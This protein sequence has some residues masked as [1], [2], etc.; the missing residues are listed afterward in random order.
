[1][2]P[3]TP[4]STGFVQ[5]FAPALARTLGQP[6]DQFSPAPSVEIQTPL[7]RKLPVPQSHCQAVVAAVAAALV[8][9]PAN[10]VVEC[11]AQVALSLIARSDERALGDEVM[12]ASAASAR[13]PPLFVPLQTPQAAERVAALFPQIDVSVVRPGVEMLLSGVDSAWAVG[14]RV[15][16][17]EGYVQRTDTP[18]L[19]FALG[20]EHSHVQHRHWVQSLG[21]RLLSAMLIAGGHDALADATAAF[22]KN[23]EFEADVGGVRFALSAG[24][25]PSAIRAATQ[26]ELTGADEKG[27]AEHPSGPDRLA[28][29]ERVLQVLAPPSA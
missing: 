13:Y 11:A 25:T 9:L 3:V 15:Y 4:L 5:R 2:Q 27:D 7:G 12:A 14:G 24:M 19:T 21:V 18:S 20:H 26:E 8:G 16:A 1:M 28:R 22:L 10:A 23:Q 6:L 17:A 29:I